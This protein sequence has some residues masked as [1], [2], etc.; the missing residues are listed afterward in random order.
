MNKISSVL[1]NRRASISLEWTILLVFIL[2]AALLAGAYILGSVLR[3]TSHPL[4]YLR[5]PPKLVDNTLYFTIYNDGKEDAN[6]QINR[7]IIKIG[8][9]TYT[10]SSVSPPS[11]TIPAG[12]SVSF[13]ATFNNVDTGG[14]A[15]GEVL[16]QTNYGE[17]SSEFEVIKG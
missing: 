11:T 17:L 15:S 7:V 12:G 6:I 5:N 9:N 16:I 14:K 10:A 8:G 1:K 4:L 13:T 3:G 2:V